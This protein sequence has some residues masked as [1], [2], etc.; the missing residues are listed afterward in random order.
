MGNL[1]TL[2]KLFAD[3]GIDLRRGALFDYALGPMPESPDFD[4]VEDAARAGSRRRAGYTT[5]GW[6][7]GSRRAR[8]GEIRYLPNEHAGN[9]AIGLPSDDTQLAFWTLGRCSKM[10]A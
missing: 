9:K 1:E 6:L 7:P 10:A 3:G 8:Y 5:E 2:E 4:R